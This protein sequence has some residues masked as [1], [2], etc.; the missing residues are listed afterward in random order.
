MGTWLLGVC[1]GLALTVGSYQ[2]TMRKHAVR[3][4][5]LDGEVAALIQ[6]EAFALGLRRAPEVRFVPASHSP[7]VAGLWRTML[8]LPAN[9]PEGF[10]RAEARLIIRHELTHVRRFDLPVNWL[11]CGLQCLHWFNPLL[12]LA[13]ARMRADRELACDAAVLSADEADHRAD[14]GHAL[15]KLQNVGPLPASSLALVGIFGRSQTIRGRIIRIAEFRPVHRSWNVLAG[16]LLMVVTFLGITRAETPPAA[17]VKAEERIQ[18]K[19]DTIILPRVVF[20]E[21]SV[22]E[23]VDYLLIKGRELD[24]SEKDPKLKGVNILFRPSLDGTPNTA[25][26]SLDLTN[27]PLGEALKYTA[28]LAN[29]QLTVRLAW[30]ELTPKPD[31]PP[32]PKRK[33]TTWIEPAAE[34]GNEVQKKL[35]QIILPRVAFS[36]TSIDEGLE[37]LRTK[38]RA[39]DVTETDPNRKGVNLVLEKN[40]NSRSA[41]ISLDLIDVPLYEALRY[42]AELANLKATVGTKAVVLTPQPPAG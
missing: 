30:V 39:L 13:F 27:V 19:L 38:S 24:T 40:E 6:Q 10:T 22:K 4:G 11:L 32:S 5:H 12:W 8:L 26:I 36:E 42:F 23:I 34:E 21:A 16:L 29:L 41:K 1:V 17:A 28:Q 2:R 14:Y 20:R 31:A 3:P 15:L 25:R 18:K 35:R 9:F 37:F 7:A 33:S